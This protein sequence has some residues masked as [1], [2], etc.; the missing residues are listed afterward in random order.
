MTEKEWD[1][2]T[3][4][5]IFALRSSLTEVS[6]LD[7]WG[8]RVT[9]A[10]STAA[11][12]SEN[13]GQ[14]ITTACRKLQIETPSPRAAADMRRVAGTIDTDYQGWA[15]HVARNIVYIVALAMCE[16]EN[17]KATKKTAKASKAADNTEEIP[18]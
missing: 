6:L 15:S 3:V 18:F 4:D 11:A 5:L 10:I 14:A 16:R 7:F 17:R 13:A 12:G 9:T 2:T 1:R 8:G